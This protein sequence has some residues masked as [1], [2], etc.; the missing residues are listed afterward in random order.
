MKKWLI[1]LLLLAGCATVPKPATLLASVTTCGDA[2]WVSVQPTS[3]VPRWELIECLYQ[4]ENESQGNHNIYITTLS[5][6]GAP[7]SGVWA[8]QAWPDGDVKQSTF[9]GTTNFGMY[10]G[11]FYPPQVGAYS[12]YIESRSISDVVN[13]MGLPANRHVN[14]LLT[15]Q[16]V[17]GNVPVTPTPF[18]IITPV[19]GGVTADRV[20]QLINDA[21][22]RAKF[23]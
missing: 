19:P 18:P 12:A 22:E 11:P 5:E 4:D 20:R 21:L 15:W 1:L 9:V 14:Y 8:H 10:G 2:T 7:K 16:Y 3:A 17:P 6:N 13:G 23:K